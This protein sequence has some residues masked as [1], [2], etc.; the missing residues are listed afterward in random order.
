[1]ADVYQQNA[2]WIMAKKTRAAIRKLKDNEGRYL[3]NADLNA[4]WGYSL[5]GKPVFA[6]DSMDAMAA[7]KDVILYGDMS[8]LAV[9]E[10]E[11]MEIEVL[12]EKFADQHAVGV[13]GWAE[14]DDKV[15]NAQK[16]AKLTMAS[17]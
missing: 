10:I 14:L 17:A 9:K 3:L 13:I 12:R 5:L 1:M 7:G 16:L 2:I 6:S 11:S 8:G 15:E 4:P